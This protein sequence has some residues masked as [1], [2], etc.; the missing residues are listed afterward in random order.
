MLV[1]WLLGLATYQLINPGAVGVWS[2][3]W[4]NIAHLLHFTPQSWMSAS[5]LSFLVAGVV[6]YLLDVAISRRPGKE[7][8]TAEAGREVDR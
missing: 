8:A 5:L 4:T 3:M 2:T 7:I 6:A 1:A